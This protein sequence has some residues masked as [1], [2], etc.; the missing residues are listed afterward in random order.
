MRLSIAGT[1]LAAVLL[2]FAPGFQAVGRS[3]ALNGSVVGSVKDSTDAVVIEAVLIL[4]N[5]ETGQSRQ[6]VSDASGAY[7]FA[8]LPPGVYDLRA[9]K[10]GFSNFVQTGIFVS[11][12]AVVR[13]DV[14]LRVGEVT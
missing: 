1:F 14:V 3:Q 6:L 9:N 4:R 8:T 7:N 12:D 13:V 2:L 5:T 10:P 11:P